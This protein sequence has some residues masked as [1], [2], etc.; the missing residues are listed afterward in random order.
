MESTSVLI[1]DFT[2]FRTVT[3]IYLLF[4]SHPIYYDLVTAAQMDYDAIYVSLFFSS[5]ILYEIYLKGLDHCSF[6]VNRIS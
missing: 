6:L 3:N 1:L 4:I 2:A 5:T